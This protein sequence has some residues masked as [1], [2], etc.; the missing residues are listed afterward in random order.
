[1]N[2]RKLYAIRIT[3]DGLRMKFRE[4][5]EFSE[6]RITRQLLERVLESFPS[7]KRWAII[8]NDGDALTVYFED[9][10]ILT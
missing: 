6:E 8:D 7:G 3:Q 1:M 4:G 10:R 5:E 2:E 9:E